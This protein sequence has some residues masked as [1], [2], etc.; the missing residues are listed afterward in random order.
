MA[1]IIIGVD[2]MVSDKKKMSK[3]KIRRIWT[4]YALSNCKK[5][6]QEQIVDY[7]NKKSQEIHK[8]H[9][10]EV[11]ETYNIKLQDF[12]MQ[13]PTISSPKVNKHNNLKLLP[14]EDKTI[15]LI[16][17]GMTSRILK[18]LKADGIIHRETIPKEGRGPDHYGYILIKNYDTLNKI[19]SKFSD[20]E[21]D[22]YFASSLA[23]LFISSKYSKEI[24][25]LKLVDLMAKRCNITFTDNEK[26]MILK[27]I[28]ISPKALFKW[29][30]IG[31]DLGFIGYPNFEAVYGYD[32]NVLLFHLQMELGEDIIC[33]LPFS[34][35]KFEYK[36]SF[37]VVD[38]EIGEKIESVIT[39]KSNNMLKSVILSNTEFSPI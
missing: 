5:W 8:L 39:P 20:P 21:L 18:S 32:K 16:S 14:K 30:N 31:Y 35:K 24:I 19:L 15:K 25:N 22:K 3:E 1:D 4:I 17:K 12:K 29:L 7:L 11:D 33:L 26:N 36:I 13:H 10:K 27:I 23:N 28:K 2:R 37:S 38:Q 6:K 34:D 9:E